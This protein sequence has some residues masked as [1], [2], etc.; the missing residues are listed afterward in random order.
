MRGCANWN[1]AK[2][3]VGLPLTLP[4]SSF[5]AKRCN[6]IPLGPEIFDGGD[7]RY[8]NGFAK[9]ILTAI[10]VASCFQSG[11]RHVHA[12][13]GAEE[14]LTLQLAVEIALRT[15]PLVRA[16]VSGREL[17]DAQLGE[18]R[19][20][21]LPLLQFSESYAN[22]NNP[23]FAFGT[24]LEQGRFGPQ[25]FDPRLLNAPP[26]INNFRTALTLKLSLFDQLQTET[27][28]AQA[29]LRQQ[30]ADRQKELV[31][32]Q[33]RFEVI[34]AY[35]GVLVAKARK[36]VADEAVE[37]AE[38][39]V[40][41]IRDLFETGLVVQ[42]DLLA[43]EVQL[44]EFHQQQI[45]AAGDVVI[46]EAALNTALGLP[47]NTPHRIEGELV[48]KTFGVGDQDELV[49]LALLHRPD[50][51]QASL[52]VR[53]S[54]QSVRSALGEFLPRFDLFATFGGSGRGLASGSADYTVGAN[55]TFNIFD[56]GRSAR[57][58][59]ARAAEAMV[60]AEQ[61]R[62]SDQI[63]FEVVRAYQ[64]YVSAQD[65][66]KVAARAVTQ[67]EETLRIVQ[68]RYQEG[69]T[70]ITEMLRAETALLRARLNV[71][72]ARYDYYVGYANLLLASGRLT[73]VQPF[74][75]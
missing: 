38:A 11:I 36:E 5:G 12:Q 2:I 28:I 41:R 18:A 3:R 35:Y 20:G 75:S 16:T 9:K 65:R 73:D 60:T 71:L 66:L 63:R 24:L 51:A 49:R 6:G 30:Q 44:A 26:S 62:L 48:E 1:W 29:R 40:K 22:S 17:A 68:D 31:E 10:L 72:T 45:Q 39:D 43:A 58:K 25:N 56:P 34:R 8:N 55:L 7:V 13:A 23:V 47:V 14:R 69:L 21:R 19:A 27:R 74:V 64:Q 52:A 53:S 42:S 54:E 15:N 61:D 37:T 32:Q 4:R 59:Q 50:Y 46:A 70:T 67:A 57:L 33:I